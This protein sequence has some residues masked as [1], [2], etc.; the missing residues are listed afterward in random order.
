MI[1]WDSRV[2]QLIGVEESSYNLSCRFKNCGDD[3]TW[4]FTRIYG[5]TKRELREEL[6]EDLGAIRGCWEGHWCLGG[7]F[8][9]LRFPGERNRRK[10]YRSYEKIISNY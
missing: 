2:V 8:N 6:C 4:I 9:V 7:D 5:P 1:L 3:F 10:M